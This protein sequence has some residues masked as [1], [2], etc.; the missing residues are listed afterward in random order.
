M[1][2]RMSH[3]FRDY[4]SKS[5][6]VEAGYTRWSHSA[7]RASKQCATQDYGRWKKMALILVVAKQRMKLQGT[8]TK[9]AY[10]GAG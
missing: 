7:I 9:H 5:C 1:L 10:Y 4:L 3:Y 6:H 2:G 8:D